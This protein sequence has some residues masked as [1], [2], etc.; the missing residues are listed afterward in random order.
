M[1]LD[2]A[3]NR[4]HDVRRFFSLETFSLKQNER[5][6]HSVQIIVLIQDIAGIILQSGHSHHSCED[7][8]CFRHVEDLNGSCELC[9]EKIRKKKCLPFQKRSIRCYW[10]LNKRQKRVSN[11]VSSMFDGR[12]IV[13]RF[14]YAFN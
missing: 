12:W 2:D 4:R 5:T 9:N 3:I 11:D 7:C 6:F 8:F 14:G 1:P 13:N 10:Q